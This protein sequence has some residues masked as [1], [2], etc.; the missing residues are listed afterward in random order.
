MQHDSSS[1]S[2]VLRAD[3]ITVVYSGQPALDQVAFTVHPGEVHALIGHNGAGKSTLASCLTSQQEPDDGSIHTTGRVALVTQHPQVIPDKPI[4]LSVYLGHEPRGVFG[5]S[6][7]KAIAVTKDLAARVGVNLESLGIDPASAGR[8]CSPAQSHIVALLAA[9]AKDPTVLIADEV[10]AGVARE[11]RHIVTDTLKTVA[12][13][14]VGVVMITHY[15]DEVKRVADQVTVLHSARAYG[16]YSV[17][18]TAERVIRAAMAGDLTTIKSIGNTCEYLGVDGNELSIPTN[19][20]ISGQPQ[21][22]DPIPTTEG[23]WPV[24]SVQKTDS[25]Q[26]A[27]TALDAKTPDGLVVWAPEP[28]NPDSPHSYRA[29]LIRIKVG[30][31]GVILGSE[32]DG[33]SPLMQAITGT[34]PMAGWVVT[35]HEKDLT[36]L[37]LTAR[38]AMGLGWV[39]DN[40]T[41]NG[42]APGLSITE[43]LAMACPNTDAKG[44]G[45]LWWHGLMR[46]RTLRAATTQLTDTW[47]ALNG[48]PARRRINQLSG[49]QAQAVMVGRELIADPTGLVLNNPQHGMDPGAMADLATKL[50]ERA[51]DGCAVLVTTTDRT[52]AQ[53]VGD[54]F[55]RASEGA[56]HPIN[57]LSR[58]AALAQPPPVPVAKRRPQTVI[59]G[60]LIAL[61]LG[62]VFTAGVIGLWGAN[63]IHVFADLV[64]WSWTT[65]AGVA[66]LL[67]HLVPI[68][69]TAAGVAIMFRSNVIS[70]GAEG[71]LY[72]G[73]LTAGI[74]AQLSGL[75]GPLVAIIAMGGGAL[76]GAV[77]AA[78][79]AILKAWLEANEIVA[80]LILNALGLL[81]CA[82]LVAGPFNAG[83][84]SLTTAPINPA[85]RLPD[86]LLGP[87]GLDVLI[88]VGVLALVA[89]VLAWSRWGL[90]TRYLGHGEARAQVMGINPKVR[91]AQVLLLGGALAGLAG[92]LVVLGPAGGRFNMVFN[93]GYGFMA[94]TVALV[95]G[96]RGWG[97]MLAGLGFATLMAGAGAIQLSA[98]IPLA[99]TG[100]I[101]GVLVLAVTM[102]ITSPKRRST[103]SQKPANPE[104]VR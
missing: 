1:P 32:R 11:E 23:E 63:P 19:Q 17:A 69:V 20:L 95:G 62:L 71:Q 13:S 59:P 26:S 39:P 73:A 3:R 85:A 4:A 66:A 40:R 41:D 50:R 15:A 55:W 14:G 68:L 28:A 57:P 30:Q 76:A 45:N 46:P 100:V 102:R 18:T 25:V 84:G 81:V 75:P 91:Q 42:P 53:L 5:V 48:I 79:A 90:G 9:M 92:A 83:Q 38:R 80:T 24:D 6:V 78:P 22:T 99:I 54:T 86:H 10:T 74:L 70:I 61:I 103:H 12:Q 35:L 101:Q 27:G 49:G 33:I 89:T 29:P 93:P 37:N 34:S 36:G 58:Q 82:W 87:I 47:R 60:P 67:A 52:F 31:V 2:P 77:W 56:I 98:G 7:R 97:M 88:A 64:H 94:I 43:N 104:T 65:P 96:H 16:P 51:A 8:T 72:L 21:H 44:Q